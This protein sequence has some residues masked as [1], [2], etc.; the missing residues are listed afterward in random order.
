MLRS[1]GGGK[2]KMLGYELLLGEPAWENYETTS[3]VQGHPRRCGRFW[4]AVWT[5]QQPTKDEFDWKII[6]TDSN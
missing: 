5:V 1:T 3:R 4:G 2:I 6:W